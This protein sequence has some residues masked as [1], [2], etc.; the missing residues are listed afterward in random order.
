MMIFSGF[1]VIALLGG[2]LAPI[3]IAAL[4]TESRGRGA[5][6]G[7]LLGLVLSWLGVVIALLLGELFV[8][9]AHGPSR[10]YRECP[11]CK[12]R[13]RRDAHVCPHCR[14][15]SPAQALEGGLRAAG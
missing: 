12:E 4:I 10:L 2:W 11:H 15:E 13:M 8:G 5:L 3:V 7:A 9:S 6:L 1:L 14:R